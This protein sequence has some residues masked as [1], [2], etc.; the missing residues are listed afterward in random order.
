VSAVGYQEQSRTGDRGL[1]AIKVAMTKEADRLVDPLE[2]VDAEFVFRRLFCPGC[3]TA[4]HSRVVPVDH[5][6]PV[7]EYR[8][9]A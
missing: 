8:S 2:Y 6:L 3:L 4:V 5:P 9:W 7:E 1:H